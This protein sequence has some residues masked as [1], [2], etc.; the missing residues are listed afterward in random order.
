MS[1]NIYFNVSKTL[2]HSRA[3]GPGVRAVIW[4]QGCT[5]GC[6]GCYSLSTHPHRKVNL[7]NPIELAKG[8]CSIEG[9][10]GITLSGGEP[11]EQSEA[12]AEFLRSVK[13][14]RPELSIF[15]FTGHEVSFLQQST[16]NHVQTVLGIAD[17]LSSGPFVAE[18]Y[19]IN[20]L[21]RGSSN[22][23]LVYLSDRYSVDNEPA[24]SSTSPV[25]EIHMHTQRLEYTGFKGKNGLIYNHLK[26]MDLNEDIAQ[27]T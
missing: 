12:V 20:L 10:E 14:I 16:N 17:M 21:W 15:I 13:E 2:M 19:D 5:I 26:K 9:I 11:F 3:N 27:T 23:Q 8:V 7:V 1:S 18:L 4:V 24:W 25:E 22:Q 6:D